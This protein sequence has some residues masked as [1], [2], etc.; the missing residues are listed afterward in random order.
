MTNEVQD[1]GP[2]GCPYLGLD[3]DRSV[4][5]LDPSPLH[6][7]FAIPSENH[8]PALQYQAA[9]CLC[10]S[11]TQCPRYLRAQPLDASI[12]RS[13]RRTASQSRVPMLLAGITSLLAAAAIAWLAFALF[14][15]RTPE[16]VVNTPV[17]DV[18]MVQAGAGTPENLVN[19]GSAT[20]SATVAIS[21]AGQ[22][23]VAGI[24]DEAVQPTPT[25]G[26]ELTATPTPTANSQGENGTISLLSIVTPTPI[27]GGEVLQLRPA[28]GNA[29]WWSN[30][31][32]TR[33]N[34][35]D[36]FLYAG[37]MNGQDYISGARFSLTRVPRGAPIDSGSLTLTGL[38]DEQLDR[39][40][41]ATWLV[42]FV[43]ESELAS[44]SNADYMML[45]SA[46]ASIT[47]L[48]QLTPAD[49]G[50]QRSNKWELDASTLQWLQDQ[51][52]AGAESVTVR[53]ISNGSGLANTLFGWDSGLGSVSSGNAPVLQLQLGPAPTQTPPLP[54]RDFVVATFTPAPGNVLTVEAE[55]QTATA[56]AA[57]IGTYTPM[58]YFVTPTPQP[59][60]LAT[61]QAAAALA[62]LPAVVL[63]TPTPA[64]DAVATE[65]AAYATAVAA[66]TGTFTPVPTA[67]VTP[68]LVLPSPPADN[69]LTEVARSAEATAVAQSGAA[70]STPLPYNAVIASYVL[71]TVTPQN[72]A[73]AAAM[74]QEAT[75]AAELV[76]T[77]TPTPW[78]W[79]VI[80][81]TPVPQTPPPTATPTLP[82]LI[83]ERDFTP[84]PTPLPIPTEVIPDVLPPEFSNKILFR[85]N[86]TGVEEI[87]LLDPVTGETGK[88][89]RDWVY[90]LA[91]KQLAVSPDGSEVAIV[92][93]DIGRVLQIFVHSPEYGTDNQVTNF[94]R[95]SY[96]PSWSPA[97]D[98]IAFVG[99]NS[100]NDEVYRASP[101]GQTVQQLTTNTYEWD[102]HPSWSP[103]GSQIVFYSNRETGRR[104]LWIMNADGSGQRNLSSNDYEDWD[105]IWTR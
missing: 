22:V 47:L 45:Y 97:G 72:V 95:D 30:S 12:P 76:G 89:T 52:L 69:L 62:N 28:T 73:T 24:S 88:I 100:G 85:T 102:K 57:T 10:A 25:P 90:P 7:C 81:P 61:V 36:S 96:D 103:D 101:D 29:G 92:K 33:P 66:T 27:P 14:V 19:A 53:I 15:S 77:A 51:R 91:E 50:L 32:P 71:A 98:W 105:P 65:Y 20:I 23:A 17:A 40:A 6:R 43:A 84:T 9:T 5:L 60:N 104:Q 39:T 18:A 11:H 38:R 42:Q 35:N 49:L 70:A 78:E 31:D 68:F 87:F 64:N 13:R 1:F 37:A 41:E 48:P 58:P 59:K 86:R 34:L 80:T 3:E 26:A 75:A 44:L 55:Q 94:T 63:E 8:T 21:P 67:Y 16:Q 56:V 46:P 82:P 79:V 93:P 83:L 4:M 74:V 2:K 99:T 54:T